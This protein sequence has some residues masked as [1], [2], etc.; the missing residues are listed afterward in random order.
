MDKF[1]FKQ[2]DIIADKGRAIVLKAN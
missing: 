1:V 2:K